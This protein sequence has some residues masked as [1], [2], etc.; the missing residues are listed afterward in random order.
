MRV[1]REFR[2][3]KLNFA[4]RAMHDSRFVHTEFHFAGFG[5]ADGF[6]NVR[7]HRSGFRVRHQPARAEHFAQTSGGLHHVRRGDYSV[8]IRPAFHDFLHHFIA[9]DEIRAGFLRFANFVSAGKN[10]HANR[11]AQAVWQNDGAANYLVGML[12]IHAQIKCQFHGLVKLRMMRLLDQLRR[13]RELVG[14]RFHFLARV[15]YVFSS[16]LYCHAFCLT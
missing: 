14:T 9:A 12:W 4:N 10:Q 11:F 16:L 2:G 7:G 1:F 6:G 8:I 5:F 3:V 13:F 15:L